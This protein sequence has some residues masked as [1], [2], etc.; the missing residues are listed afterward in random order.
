MKLSIERTIEESKF[1]YEQFNGMN[2]KL[3]NILINTLDLSSHLLVVRDGKLKLNIENARM[4]KYEDIYKEYLKSEH[5]DLFLP[6]YSEFRE[7][8]KYLTLQEMNTARWA[9]DRLKSMVEGK[10][11]LPEAHKLVSESL[12]IGFIDNALLKELYRQAFRDLRIPFS[13]KATLIRSNKYVVC[14]QTSI[15]IEGRLAFGYNINKIEK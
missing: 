9:K 12:S 8:E 1:L 3:Q 10:K 4:F 6:E 15:K 5:K 2:E 11:R 13:S 7:Y 14:Y